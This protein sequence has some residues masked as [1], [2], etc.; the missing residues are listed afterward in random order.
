MHGNFNARS[1]LW[2]QHGTNQEGCVLEEALSDALFTPM[3]T[4][5]PTHTATRQGY[6]DSTV[7]LALVSP[8]LAP[9]TRAKTV[10]S[11]GS[12]HLSVDFSLQKSGIEPRRKPQY[13]FKTPR[14]C[15]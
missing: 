4:T 7:D 3:S 2:D 11:H 5:S 10:A 15:Q 13:Q 12:D 6:T 1:S 14:T 9:W 8:K